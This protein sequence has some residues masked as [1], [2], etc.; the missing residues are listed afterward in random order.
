MLIKKD[1]SKV[2]YKEFKERLTKFYKCEYTYGGIKTIY[3]YLNNK[4]ENIQF[5]E[6]HQVD[7]VWYFWEFN[8]F[9]Y[10]VDALI[11]TGKLWKSAEEI[12]NKNDS[13]NKIEKDCKQFIENNFKCKIL[14][15]KNKNIKTQ[16]YILA[17]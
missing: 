12:Y 6:L 8:K 14:P 2:T 11:K 15:I 7:Y 16:S 1:N 4:K 17:F 10:V 9:Y 3:N 13:E 5:D